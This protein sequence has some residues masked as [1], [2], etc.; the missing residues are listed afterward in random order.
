M[1]SLFDS[2]VI[3]GGRGM[4]AHALARALAARGYTPAVLSKDECDITSEADRRRL[5]EFHRPTLLLNC[6]AYTKVDLAEQE[7][8]KANALN[9]TAPGDLALLC[10]EHRTYLVHYS[11]DFV[12]D[13]TNPL[14]YRETDRA[15][16]LSAYGRSKLAGE[17]AIRAADHPPH[18]ICRTAWLYGTPGLCFPRTMVTAARA[19]KPLSVVSDQ[20]GAPTFTDDLAHA[21]LDLIRAGATGTY[22]VTNAGSTT[23]FDFTKAILHE[24]GLPPAASPITSDDWKQQRPASATRPS[25]STLDLTKLTRTIHRP[26]RHWRDALRDYR[27]Q[28][29]VGGF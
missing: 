29:D 12:F 13:G 3:T 15:Y 8:D 14:P 7:P 9:A 24:F 18:L 6:A 2:I 16:P 17:N 22:H 10:K 4:L 28:V 11:T 1:P 20:T 25:N 27:Q 23:W 26:M 19:G 5:F 21:T